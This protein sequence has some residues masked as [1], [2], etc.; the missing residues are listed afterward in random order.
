MK[1][2]RLNR[3][4]ATVGKDHSYFR[5][6]C[7][8]RRHIFLLFIVVAS[9]TLDVSRSDP[10]LALGGHR[11]KE[12][13]LLTWSSFVSRLVLARA[14]QR[15]VHVGVLPGAI[16]VVVVALQTFQEMAFV[17]SSSLERNR[18]MWENCAACLQY[19]HRQMETDHWLC[20]DAVWLQYFSYIYVL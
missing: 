3:R 11:K 6:H 7:R 10:R 15:H 5:Q 12:N 18:E 4:D 8:H 20:L 1:K 16:G 19:V 2:K 14:L 17:C 9:K 13:G